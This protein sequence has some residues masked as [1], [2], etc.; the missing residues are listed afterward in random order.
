LKKAL[1]G[2]ISLA[3]ITIGSVD[4]IRNLPAAAL[5][6]SDIFQYFLLALFLFLLPA[7]FIAV[8][9]SYQCDKG[10]YGWV[11]LGL[12][13][14]FGMLAIWFQWL[15]NLLIY[16]TFFS[17]IA[18]AI[19]YTFAPSLIENKLYL[20]II[21]NLILWC[22]TWLNIKGLRL[23]STINNTLTFV[24]LVLPFLLII[25]IGIDYLL[26]HS[27]PLANLPANHQ[28]SASCLTAIILSFCGIEI[29]AVHA[30]KIHKH[31]YTLAIIAA[32][33]FI[34]LSMLFGALTLALLIPNHQLNFISDIPAL[35]T[36][37]FNQQKLA[38]FAPLVNGFIILGCLACANNWLLAPIKGIAFAIDDGP[39]KNYS[40]RLTLKYLLILQ[41]IAISLASS[42]F[43]LF[44]RINASYWFMMTLATEMYLLMY[45]LMFVA[46][47]GLALRKA[48]R[49][50]AIIITIASIGLCGILFTFWAS[51]SPP[52]ISID[53]SSMTYRARLAFALCIMCLPA[54]IYMGKTNQLKQSA[55]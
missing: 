12:G 32:V 39:K 1:K 50:K 5:V 15:Q 25:Y 14:P 41:A 53:I 43:F 10:I 36:L 30:K 26:S 23:S 40:Q 19:L 47:I 34:F 44:K 24:G 13:K 31:S 35:F 38:A 2:T 6:G 51:F 7:A 3:L 8:W 17:F 22:L 27:N 52:P 42:L 29:A 9:L 11:S 28:G 33:I 16:P 4:S 49:H 37:F 46:A 54:L 18:G 45:V 20:F 48:S 55:I 21:I